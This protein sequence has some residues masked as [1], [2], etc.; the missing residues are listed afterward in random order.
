MNTSMRVLAV[1]AG[2]SSLKLALFEGDAATTRDLLRIRVDRHAGTPPS[3]SGDDSALVAA[4]LTGL[5]TALDRPA[6]THYADIVLAVIAA[7]APAC[8]VDAVVHRVVHGGD[9]ARECIPLDAAQR[10]RLHALSVLAPLHQPPALAI[11]DAVAAAHPALAQFAG[12]DTAFHHGLPP[13][14]RTYALPADVRARHPE[15]RTWGF[16]GLSCRWSVG[17]LGRRA[18]ELPPKLVIAHLGSGASLTAV[19]D[20]RSLATTMGFSALEGLV[21]AT[22]PGRL[23]PGVLLHLLRH[24]TPDVDALEEL[25]YRRSGLLGLSGGISADLRVLL[26]SPAPAAQAAVELFVHRAA[27]ECGALAVVLGGIDAIVFTGGIGEHQ[28]G[29]RSRIAAKVRA[30]APG[31]RELVIAC[32]EEAVMAE[33]V[34]GCL[35]GTPRGGG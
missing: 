7:L 16:H 14:A 8:P 34:R 25:L 32:D 5:A 28:P 3:V 9:E 17:Q 21:M 15:L 27:T 6:S 24:E 23:D 19:R 12:L 2:S 31:L 33:A 4:V 29:I 10:K 20:G 18:G 22:R 11:I 30:V 35:A 26:D 1:N 13:E